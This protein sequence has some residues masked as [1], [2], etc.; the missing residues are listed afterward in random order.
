[1]SMKSQILGFQ[2]HLNFF[3]STLFVD[4]V[5][6]VTNISSICFTPIFPTIVSYFI[7]K[8]TRFNLVTQAVPFEKNRVSCNAFERNYYR[9]LLSRTIILAAAGNAGARISPPTIGWFVY[10]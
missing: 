3:N 6:G 8:P 10:R 4:Q 9:H 5:E 7:C 1:M 2:S